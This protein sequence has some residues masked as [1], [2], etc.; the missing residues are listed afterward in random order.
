MAE[1][2][3]LAIQRIDAANATDPHGKELLY[4]QRMTDWL[5]RL[6]P[7]P[8]EALQIAARAQHIM[9]WKLPRGEYPMDRAG[10]H[11]WRTRLYD[12]HADETAQI[13]RDI[14]YEDATITRVRSLIRKE[15]IK[16]DPEMQAL[17]DVI[18]VVFLEHYFHEFARDHDQA[19]LITILQRTWKKMSDAGRKAALSL[20]LPEDD[21][22]IIAKALAA[23]PPS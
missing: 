18:C 23:P 17:E 22:A 13:L 1:R 16:S 7:N 14:G 10:Y 15:R 11:K 3:A 9:R 4:S 5:H 20:P 12:F 8:S 2:L 21:R 19:K 6:A